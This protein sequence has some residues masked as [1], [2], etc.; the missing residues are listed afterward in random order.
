MTIMTKYFKS[1]LQLCGEKN[2]E[3][4]PPLIIN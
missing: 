2:R 3:L 4:V 1:R